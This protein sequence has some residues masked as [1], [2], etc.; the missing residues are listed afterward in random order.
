MHELE[1]YSWNMKKGV[2]YFRGI[3]KER[4]EVWN[5]AKKEKGELCA[6]AAAYSESDAF[7]SM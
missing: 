1:E 2:L 6:N 5:E 3:I 7:R 4:I